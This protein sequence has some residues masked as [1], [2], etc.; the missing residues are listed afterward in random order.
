LTFLANCR[1]ECSRSNDQHGILRTGNALVV[2][3]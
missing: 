1:I 3:L 2:G